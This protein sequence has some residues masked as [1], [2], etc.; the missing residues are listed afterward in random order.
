LQAVISRLLSAVAR[1]F[2]V[3]LLVATPGLM[4]PGISEDGAQVVVLVA[5]AAAA[6]TM[7]E[8]T[9]SYPSLF[10]FRDAPPFNRIRFANLFFSV[11][12]ISVLVRHTVDPGQLTLL[13]TAV[14][15]VVGRAIDFPYSPVRLVILMLPED[16]SMADVA[17]VRSAAGLA[18]TI[19]TAAVLIFLAIVRLTRWPMD[20]GSFNVWINLPTFDPTSGGDVVG[21]LSRDGRIN[22]A[23]GILLPFLMPAVVNAAGALFGP[24]SIGNLQ[25]MIWTVAAWAFLPSSLIARGLA[26]QRVAA[27]IARKRRETTATTGGLVPA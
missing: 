1:G 27:I 23:L 22:V 20:S 16:A 26:M 2:L 21:R 17:L 15:D 9:S 19:S 12:L 10:E 7:L 24:M 3:L 4:A 5:L 13:V 11:F 25:T 14:G 8:Y 18:F 6:M